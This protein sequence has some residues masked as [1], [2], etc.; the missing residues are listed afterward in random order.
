[1]ETESH[2][3]LACFRCPAELLEAID[4]LSAAGGLSRS[5]IIIKAITQMNKEVRRRN[6]RIIPPLSPDTESPYFPTPDHSPPPPPPGAG[7]FE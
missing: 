2:D 1:M 7:A 6:G 4:L 5:Y 3:K